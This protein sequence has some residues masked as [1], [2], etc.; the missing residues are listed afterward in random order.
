MT[1]ENMQS[2]AL[3]GGT[4]LSL[5][6]GHRQSID[7]DFFSTEAFQVDDVHNEIRRAYKDTHLINRTDG[8]LC[9]EIKNVKIDILYHPYPMLAST[10]SIDSIRLIALDDLAA[11]KINAVTNRGSKKD[12]SD[13]LLLH[14]SGLSLQQS[15][16]LFCEKYGASAKFLAIRSLQYFEDA[17]LEPDPLYLNEWTWEYVEKR[18]HEIGILLR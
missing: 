11:M 7:L 3:G 8:S 10:D 13:L 14:E 12:F 2:F 16:S 6:F 4:S 18:V 15:L 9:L 5:R 1:L 17:A